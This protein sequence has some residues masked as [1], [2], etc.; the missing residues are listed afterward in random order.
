[1]RYVEGRDLA[2]L[3]ESVGR[4]DPERAADLL[5]QIASALDAAH[6]RDLVHRDV[7]P[8]NIL[9]SRPGGGRE[10]AY[11]C[12][13][14]LAKHASTVSSLTGSREILGTVD[15]LAPEQIEGK[16]MDGR[17]DVY[18]L[19]CVLHECLTGEPPYERENEIA[20]LLAHVNDP[21]PAVSERRPELPEAL[22]AVIASALAKERDLRYS[23][24]GELLEA[25][26]A[27][28]HGEAPAAPEAA[29]TAAPGIRTFLFADV[30]GYTTYT[31]EHGDEAAA[32]LAE[33]FAAIVERL[34]PEHSGTLQELRG[35]EALVVFD[36]ARRALRFGLELQRAVEEEELARP[37]GIG[38]DAGEATPVEG[39]F[40]GGAL[41]RAARL[42][43]LARPG[44]VLASDAVREL[45]GET[46]GVA[47]GFRRVERLKGFEK[48]G[49][50]GL[51]AGRPGDDRP[52]RRDREAPMGGRPCGRRRLGSE[53]Q[54]RHR[55]SHRPRLGPEGHLRAR[56]PSAR[57]RCGKRPRL[58]VA[59]PLGGG[60]PLEDRRQARGDRHAA[61]R[62]DRGDRQQRVPNTLGIA[63]RYATGS[64]LMAY[65][66]GA[67]GTAAIVPEVAAGPPT[68]SADGLTYTFR[69]RK[70][71][72]S[73]RPRPRR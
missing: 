20:S 69:V 26:R 61:R 68:V 66:L 33:Q 6:A 60:C 17:V 35:D 48:P 12:D 19:G 29:R 24:C 15:Y 14:G 56:P 67:G 42:C 53:R 28:L 55:H 25:A 31:R 70:D 8:A 49:R 50:R 47:F 37:V 65:R 1:M 40:R 44:E 13:F 16:P 72:G 5:A 59:R 22:D 41:N 10:H 11:L 30:R 36:S 43:A 64:G 62:S 38:L 51:E 3:L 18:A 45:T 32:E 63:F 7:K 9:I 73:R 54:R 58:R 39:G 21:P 4:L 57:A 2:A 46:E 71:S 52:E 23:T 34:A 27:A